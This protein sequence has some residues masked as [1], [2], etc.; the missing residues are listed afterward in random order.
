M[1]TPRPIIDASAGADRG[2]VDGVTEQP[3]PEDRDDEAD[4]R[5]PERQQRGRDRAERHEQDHERSEQAD[6][7]G[8]PVVVLVEHLGELVRGRHHDVG[9]GDRAL[10]VV[11]QRGGQRL[12]DVAARDGEGDVDRAGRAVDRQLAVAASS[13]RSRSRPAARPSAPRPPSAAR[14]RRPASRAT[15]HVRRDRCGGLPAPGN[16]ARDVSIAAWLSAPGI[17]TSSVVAAPNRATRSPSTIA[18]RN[19]APMTRRGWRADDRPSRAVQPSGE[20]GC[21]C[22][23]TGS[24]AGAS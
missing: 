8:P 13:A 16:A 20:S 11:E 6:Q 3:E 4:D 22:A 19:H 15:E 17:V 14:R 21:A 10:D 9:S 12:G 1:P 2:D 18:R 23:V 7:L 5:D 24:S